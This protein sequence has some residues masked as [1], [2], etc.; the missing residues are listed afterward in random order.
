MPEQRREGSSPIKKNAAKRLVKVLAKAGHGFLQDI[1]GR[2]VGLPLRPFVGE[3]VVENLFDRVRVRKRNE[4]LIFRHVL[5]VVD[6]QRLDVIGQ[7]NLNRR[8]VV[9]VLFLRLMLAI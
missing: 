1:H 2:G 4:L 3:V 6:E 9:K 5:P 7:G 8:P